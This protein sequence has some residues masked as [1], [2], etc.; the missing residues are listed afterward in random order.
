MGTIDNPIY[1]SN[2]AAICVLVMQSLEHKN[3]VYFTFDYGNLY[4]VEKNNDEKYSCHLMN[5]KYGSRKKQ[6]EKML[7]EMPLQ[8]WFY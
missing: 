4:Y 1:H 3:R 2:L 8:E 5:S 6:V 7:N